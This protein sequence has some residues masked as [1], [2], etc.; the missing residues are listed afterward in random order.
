MSGHI[1]DYKVIACSSEDH[2]L[3]KHISTLPEFQI[4]GNKGTFHFVEHGSV[5]ERQSLYCSDSAEYI[6]FTVHGYYHNAEN[7]D[8]QICV[9]A[10]VIR[11]PGAALGGSSMSYSQG[12]HSDDLLSRS[13]TS[14]KNPV[15]D[16]GRYSPARTPSRSLVSPFDPNKHGIKLNT[17]SRNN[18]PIRR[19]PLPVPLPAPTKRRPSPQPQPPPIAKANLQHLFNSDSED[20]EVIFTKSMVKRLNSKLK[21][22]SDTPSTSDRPNSTGSRAPTRSPSRNSRNSSKTGER[23]DSV[24]IRRPMPMDKDEKDLKIKT[25]DPDAKSEKSADSG[26]QSLPEDG[27]LSPRSRDRILREIAGVEF[28]GSGKLSDKKKYYFRRSMNVYNNT[29]RILE[30]RKEEYLYKEQYGVVDGLQQQLERLY[31]KEA[32]LRELLVERL[33]A[34]QANKYQQAQNLKDKF[35]AQLADAVDLEK[36]KKYLSKAETSS[37]PTTPSTAP[38][39]TFTVG[40][41]VTETQRGLIG[42]SITAGVIPLALQRIRDLELI[43]DVDFE[44]IVNYTDCTE[45][46]AAGVA[47]DLLQKQDV[48]VILGPPCANAIVPVGFLTSFYGT[49]QVAGVNYVD[50]ATTLWAARGGVRPLTTPICGYKGDDCPLSTWEKSGLYIVIGEVIQ[51]GTLTLDAFFAMALIKDLVEGL[52][53]VHRSFLGVHG[54]LSS[55]TCW[56]DERWQLKVSGFGCKTL[57][58]G[59]PPEKRKIVTRKSVF[60]LENRDEKLEELLYMIKR[61]SHLPARPDLTVHEEMELN[62]AM[63][64]LIRDCW[65]ESPMK[66]PDLGIVKNVMKSM[67][68]SSGQ[69]NL[70]DH[71]FNIMES[72]AET[73]EKEVETRMAELVEEKK[74]S[75]IL[76]YRMLPRQ[77]ADRLKLGQSVE[78]ESFD[79]V[80]IFFSD[81]V[82]FTNLAAKCTP[83]QIVT[84]L[85]DLYT[86]FD[87]VIEQHHVYKVETIGDGYLCVSG[88]P[89]R[90][91][92]QHVKDIAE[93]SLGFFREVQMF[94]VP[95]LPTQTI[96]LRIGMHSGSCVAGVVGLAMPRY[97]LFGDTVNTASRMES[98]GKPG[99]IHMSADAA[100][101]LSRLGGYQI[102]SRGEVMIKGKGVMETFWLEVR[103]NLGICRSHDSAT[104]QRH[105]VCHDTLQCN[106]LTIYLAFLQECQ[107]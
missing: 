18:S 92:N 86:T 11:A 90:N 69:Q 22:P 25:T 16:E 66:R 17:S 28:G 84:L 61:G 21:D 83:L 3:Q 35:D 81:V 12:A 78:P 6:R 82:Q 105:L 38:R 63:I 65:D 101:L 106:L 59:E 19:S 102:E 98:N 36:L 43:N 41:I 71:V 93:M 100:A 95:H 47:V 60:D 27:P 10:I 48:D 15:L 20:E 42:F 56:I 103:R 68:T 30:G 45:A 2:E 37:I 7:E 49:L 62:P 87:T 54:N 53:F 57:R 32:P 96:N 70:M 79:S 80:T 33:D 58:Q 46:N 94:R 44:F 97:C 26:R 31:A 29:I 23:P 4:T 52:H 74:K 89:K 91:G 1:I 24:Q 88:L 40:M 5:N 34:L 99:K 72:Y 107:P 64:H 73:L 104:L 77:V 9:A 50:D 67:S 51:K 8:R 85:N 13:I 75:D 55:T 14:V 76:L 39:T